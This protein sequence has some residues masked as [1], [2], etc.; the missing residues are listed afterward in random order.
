[1]TRVTVP[2]ASTSGSP[3]QYYVVEERVTHTRRY[4]K[5]SMARQEKSQMDTMMEM[6]MKMR[7]EYRRE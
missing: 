1:M 3:E 7:E 4:D 5:G 2:L 6:F